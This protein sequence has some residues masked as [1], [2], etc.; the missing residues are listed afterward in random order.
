[1]SSIGT[2][3]TALPAPTGDTTS[4]LL[5]SGGVDS[6]AVAAWRR[7]AVG[8][9]VDYGQR[10]AK[11]E[12]RAAGAV[13]RELGIE[14][15]CVELDLGSLGGG[16][17]RDDEEQ[18]SWPSPEWW[19]YRNQFLISAAAAWTL[20][21]FNDI[22]EGP[23]RILVECGTVASDGARHA[24]GTQLFYETMD[25]LLELQ[26]GRIR[27][28]APAISMTSDELLSVSEVDAAT[29]GWTHSCHRS[30]T[31]CGECPGCFKREQLLDSLGRPR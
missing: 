7:P 26:E 18:P 16:L 20:T 1:M 30:D 14:F 17:L 24:D 8:L 6:A 21:R 23:R 10:P 9:F 31:P 19:P 29:L 5:L 28:Q 13:A 4:V 3:P 11:A 25:R 22:V 27:V 15:A 2:W 12:Y